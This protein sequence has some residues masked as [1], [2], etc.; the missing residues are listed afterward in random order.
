V[1]CAPCGKAAN[2]LS[3]KR[4]AQSPEARARDAAR[5]KRKWET[6]PAFRQAKMAYKKAWKAKRAAAESPTDGPASRRA[7]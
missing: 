7:A 6:D 2:R 4:A 5:F 3:M 1:F